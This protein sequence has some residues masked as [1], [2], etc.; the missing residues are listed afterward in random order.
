MTAAVRDGSLFIAGL[1]DV[2]V[3]RVFPDSLPL[4][5]RGIS[6]LKLPSEVGILDFRLSFRVHLLLFGVSNV[7]II[8]DWLPGCCG[9]KCADEP[10]SA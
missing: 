2:F 8:Q 3:L 10:H 6:P 5:F 7:N 9:H 4:T 1:E